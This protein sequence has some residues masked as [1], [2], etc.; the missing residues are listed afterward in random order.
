MKDAAWETRISL[1]SHEEAA[2]L[3]LLVDREPYVSFSV[4]SWSVIV[5]LAG[6]PPDVL[7]LLRMD[8]SELT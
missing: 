8:D 2:S 1:L 5:G 6:C 7:R 3:N 4:R